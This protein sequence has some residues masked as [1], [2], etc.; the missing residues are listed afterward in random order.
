MGAGSRIPHG[1]PI[2]L[3]LPKCG[4]PVARQHFGG[5]LRSGRGVE[6]TYKLVRSVVPR[7]T[8]DR[9]PAPDIAAIAQLIRQGAF[10]TRGAL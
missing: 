10:E 1:Y 4:N 3:G 6:R 9:P 8:E 2:D 5:T 7:L